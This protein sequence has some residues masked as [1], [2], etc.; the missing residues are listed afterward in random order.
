MSDERGFIRVDCPACKNPDVWFRCNGCGKSDQ[1]LLAGGEVSCAC[2]A[3][4]THGNCTCGATVPVD[5]LRFVPF[6]KGPMALAD[7]EI[8][9][10]RVAVL[11][12]TVVAVIALGVWWVLS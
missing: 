4:Y 12:T 5:G 9:W 6:E 2:S 3:R 1:F 11:G 8:H 7:L 10:G